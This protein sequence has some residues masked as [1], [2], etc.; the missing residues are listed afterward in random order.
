MRVRVYLCVC[1]RVCA[2]ARL[3]VWLCARACT[4]Y[5][6]ERR[7][8]SAAALCAALC[9]PSHR[10]AAPCGIYSSARAAR[11]RPRAWLRSARPAGCRARSAAGVTWTCRTASAP[12]AARFGHTSVVDARGAIYV[13]GGWSGGTAY[14][15][16]VWVST[17]GGARAG[18]RRG[19]LE[20]Y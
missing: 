15:N 18:L 19:V 14:F 10:T 1:A 13:I 3:L 17:D 5:V 12:W 6:N 16:D 4:A 8:H 9:A 2:R 7:V 11:L 20:G